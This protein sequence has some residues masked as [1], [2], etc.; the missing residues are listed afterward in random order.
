VGNYNPG[1]FDAGSITSDAVAALSIL[2]ANPTLFGGAAG[3]GGYLGSSMGAS[4]FYGGG[5]GAPAAAGGYQYQG[6]YQY[7]YQTPPVVLPHGVPVPVP[8]GV[9][10][11]GNII[12]YMSIRLTQIST[13]ELSNMAECYFTSTLL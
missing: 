11:L 4:S 8:V 1:L 3:A 10:R 12:Y 2:A 7:H 5:G 13:K 9:Q 6:G